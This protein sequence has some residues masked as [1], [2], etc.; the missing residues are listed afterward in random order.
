MKKKSVDKKEGEKN[1]LSD[2]SETTG[3]WRISAEMVSK[4][5]V[6]T[7]RNNEDESFPPI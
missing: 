3:T 5:E 7:V 1:L 6:C 2:G 4:P